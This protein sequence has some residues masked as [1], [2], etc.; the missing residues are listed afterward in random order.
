[1][2]C[3]NCA[4]LFRSYDVRCYF[5]ANEVGPFCDRCDRIIKA[6]TRFHPL[7]GP[8]ALAAVDP[9]VSAAGATDPGTP[10]TRD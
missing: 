6:H 3:I 9:H 2:K 7:D 10:T 5:G 8:E 4:R 1:M